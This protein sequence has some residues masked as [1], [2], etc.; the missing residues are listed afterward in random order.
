MNNKPHLNRDQK[1]SILKDTLSGK[2]SPSQFRKR[3]TISATD[4][5]KI[6]LPSCL[7]NEELVSQIDVTL[8]NN[9]VIYLSEDMEDTLVT[10]IALTR[11]NQAPFD[12]LTEPGQYLLTFPQ[13][14]EILNLSRYQ[15][16]ILDIK[17][18]A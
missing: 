15:G 1:A 17:K 8:G 7:Q 10:R 13:P 4:P 11:N 12:M 9:G 6:P 5:N 14:L 18:T 16:Q 3:L 2:L